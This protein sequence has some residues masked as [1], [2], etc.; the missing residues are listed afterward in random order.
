GAKKLDEHRDALTRDDPLLVTALV[1][2]PY[3]EGEAVRER[4]R[5]LDAKPLAAIRAE[6]STTLDVRLNADTITADNLVALKSLILAHPGACRTS[7]RLHIPQR[8]ETVLDLGDD[9]KVAPNDE[10]LAR[11]DQLF[12]DRVAV[13][14]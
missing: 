10:L 12:G 5:F 7:L 11:I 8:S 3:G 6:R 4:L 9:H 13:L 2:A 1:D 14:R